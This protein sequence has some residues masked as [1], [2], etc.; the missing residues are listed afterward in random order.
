M[1]GNAT[2]ELE[3]S[4][5]AISYLESKLDNVIDFELPKDTGKRTLICIEKEKPSDITKLRSY[6]KIIKKPLQKKS[7]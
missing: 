5:Y 1:K 2:E 7:I 6:E 4:K 3:N